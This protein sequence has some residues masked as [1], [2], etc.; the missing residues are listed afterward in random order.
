MLYKNITCLKYVNRYVVYQK[1]IAFSVVL[2]FQV[3]NRKCKIV[4]S[5]QLLIFL[6]FIKPNNVNEFFLRNQQHINIKSDHKIRFI[7]IISS[8][9]T[10]RLKLKTFAVHKKPED[11]INE[12][13]LPGLFYFYIPS[14]CEDIKRMLPQYK[15]IIQMWYIT[16]KSVYVQSWFIISRCGT[17]LVCP[18]VMT[19][20]CLL[21][22][23]G[24][25]AT[26]K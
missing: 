17:G 8:L 21:M 25:S 7:I 23:I 26:G 15:K 24:E 3:F 13:I 19:F 1:H 14:K 20:L 9:D 22:L 2:L 4:I 12:E 11:L 6:I 10:F 18:F 16:D 5:S